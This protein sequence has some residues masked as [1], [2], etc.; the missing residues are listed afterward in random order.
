MMKN[1]LRAGHEPW[2]RQRGSAR[3]LLAVLALIATA[4]CSGTDGPADQDEEVGSPLFN[5]VGVNTALWETSNYNQFVFDRTAL[6]MAESGF[7][8][9]PPIVNQSDEQE[10]LAAPAEWTREYG[11]GVSTL[12]FDQDVVGPDLKG[13]EVQAGQEANGLDRNADYV[14]E[15]SEPERDAYFTEL[16][17][18]SMAAN[19]E[20]VRQLQNSD[21][22]DEFGNDLK[23]LEIDVDGDPRMISFY[24]EVV[25]C[26]EQEG[27]S[28]IGSEDDAIILLQQE[29]QPLLAAVIRDPTADVDEAD[30]ESIDPE[31]GPSLD[32]IELTS[33]QLRLLGELQDREISLASALTGCGG[34]NAEL[35][36]LR[37]AVRDEYEVRFMEENL[38]RLKPFE[39]AGTDSD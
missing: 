13:I 37:D 15:L 32:S 23:Q 9:Y 16:N 27:Y 30:L 34:T 31:A 22:L 36:E 21:F 4:G 3:A 1:P 19:D 11:F 25:A 6:C 39:G 8:W 20:A 26:M 28:A 38:D 5:Y 35:F 33:D 24:D 18:C 10:N 12:A 17:D 2:R 14:N 29:L 7:D